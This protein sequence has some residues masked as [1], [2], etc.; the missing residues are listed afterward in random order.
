M[1]KRV[2]PCPRP[3]AAPDLSPFLAVQQY[4]AL[5]GVREVAVPF[6]D[7]L[8]DLV[9]ADAVRTRRDFP[10]LLT[11]IQAVAFLYQLQRDRTPEG[12]VVATIEDYARAREIFVVLL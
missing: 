3:R 9:P 5:R 8:A 2:V 4:L 10:Q 6:A 11:A 7:V 12:W 1:P